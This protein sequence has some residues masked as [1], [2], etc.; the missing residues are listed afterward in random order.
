MRVIDSFLVFLLTCS[1]AVLE[2]CARIQPP[3]VATTTTAVPDDDTTAIMSTTTVIDET[4][5]TTLGANVS[6]GA[7]MGAPRF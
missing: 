1:P 4:T 2:V 5:T 6:Q 7:S 3:V